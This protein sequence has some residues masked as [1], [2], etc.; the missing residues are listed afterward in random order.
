MQAIACTSCPIAFPNISSRSGEILRQ[1]TPGAHL[2]VV[3]PE[4]GGAVGG[5]LAHL[6]GGGMGRMVNR[7]GVALGWN[8]GGMAHGRAWVTCSGM[9]RGQ[10]EEPAK[11]Q[12]QR[13]SRAWL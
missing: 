6:G 8:G 7:Q 3:L 9:Q 4:L 13:S 1:E 10:R 11:P 12:S 2:Q 5:H